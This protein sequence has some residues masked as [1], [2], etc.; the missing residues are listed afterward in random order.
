[1]QLS[2]Y[3]N[4]KKQC[5][6]ISKGI[7]AK[8]KK[9]E[10]KKNEIRDLYFQIKLAEREIFRIQRSMKEEGIFTIRDDLI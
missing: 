3:I 5:K 1:M 4:K 10:K 9:I 7:L 2:E 8:K 6:I